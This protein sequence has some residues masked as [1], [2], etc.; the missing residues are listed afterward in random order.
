MKVSKNYPQIQC[1]ILEFQKLKL[2]VASYVGMA[3][4]CV[5]TPTNMC[6]K[7]QFIHSING[8]RSKAVSLKGDITH[9]KCKK[10]QF[11]T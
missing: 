2:S 5:T 4:I 11:I 8:D 10:P 1:G 3:S 6:K 9:H 7:Q